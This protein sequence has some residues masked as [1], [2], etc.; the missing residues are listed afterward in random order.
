MWM[1]F[2]T[3]RNSRICQI[4]TA[5]ATIHSELPPPH[6][7]GPACFCQPRLEYNQHGIPMFI[8]DHPLAKTRRTK[9]G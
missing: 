4:D 2:Y 5:P 3:H 9:P 7:L 1:N 6:I 8:H